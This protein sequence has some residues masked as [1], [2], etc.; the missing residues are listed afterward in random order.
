MDYAAM[1]AI[2]GDLTTKDEA[3]T[4]FT[5]YVSADNLQWFEDSGLIEIN[6]PVHEA[7]GIQY[8]QREWTV[9]VTD[10]GLAFV[11]TYA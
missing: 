9:T 3:G 2:L 4:H 8:E 7:S 1:A 11:E 10:E 6:R 5:E